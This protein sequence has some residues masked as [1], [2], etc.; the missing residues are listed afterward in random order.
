MMRTGPH[1]R[2]LK[3]FWAPINA[4]SRCLKQDFGHFRVSKVAADVF[5]RFQPLLSPYDIRPHSGFSEKSPDTARSAE[6][7][8][9]QSYRTGHKRQEPVGDEL[10]LTTR[11]RIQMPCD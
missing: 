8:K 4:E 7:A 3:Q 5:M 11:I 6:L 2:F 9:V 10:T 1:S